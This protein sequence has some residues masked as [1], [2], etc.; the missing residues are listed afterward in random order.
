MFKIFLLET[1]TSVELDPKTRN[2]SAVCH[3]CLVSLQQ[4]DKWQH[5]SLELQRKIARM[6]NET[7]SEQIFIKQE[8]PFNDYDDDDFNNGARE[9]DEDT[10]EEPIAK[11]RKTS[12]LESRQ[13][14]KHLKDDNKAGE[15]VEESDED[16][17]TEE[18]SNNFK[19]ST[20]E[21]FFCVTRSKRFSNSA[22][23]EIHE[24][25]EFPFP[26]TKYSKGFDKLSSLKSHYINHTKLRSLCNK[27]G[28]SFDTKDLLE[29][30]MQ[31]HN[32]V[33]SAGDSSRTVFDSNKV[34]K[35]S[36]SPALPMFC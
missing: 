29:V 5:K 36:Y 32:N 28:A 35:Q 19:Q 11:I 17:W 23:Q 16:W 24:R 21:D 26:C 25:N 1:C 8:P 20:E 3:E 13:N 34:V 18:A 22:Q 14:D 15:N 10:D 12:Q 4:Y 6:L 9:T 27:C 31:I 33:N 2:D 30:H 7:R